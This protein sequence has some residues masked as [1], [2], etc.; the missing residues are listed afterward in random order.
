VAEGGAAPLSVAQHMLPRRLSGARPGKCSATTGGAARVLAAPLVVARHFRF[1]VSRLAP[2]WPPPSLP[3]SSLHSKGGCSLSPSQSS[4]P[5]PPKSK[6]FSVDFSFPTSYNKH[7]QAAHGMKA[8]I[9]NKNVAKMESKCTE[10]T[11]QLIT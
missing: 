10:W 1:R 3:P 8:N 2:S 9:N 4:H 6:L 5:K 11:K 7:R